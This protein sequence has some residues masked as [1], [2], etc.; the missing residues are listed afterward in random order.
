M[1]H[2]W[3]LYNEA[4]SGLYQRMVQLGGISSCLDEE[5]RGR[6]ATE[7]AQSL[8]MLDA[9]TRFECEQI[10]RDMVA[11]PGGVT[12]TPLQAY[13]LATRCRCALDTISILATKTLEAAPFTPPRGIWKGAVFLEWLLVANWTERHDAWL[14][15][16]AHGIATGN[17][18]YSG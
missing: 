12:C 6:S 9:R 1:R 16:T 10:V 11:G 5:L 7:I 14:K 8:A 2:D 15:L 17:Q 13:M 4:I 18:Y 3:N